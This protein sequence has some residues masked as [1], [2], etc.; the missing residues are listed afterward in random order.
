M[1]LTLVL[2]RMAHAWHIGLRSRTYGSP[3]CRNRLYI[4]GVR[5]DIADKASFN[6]AIQYFR[7]GLP[8]VS[9]R[10]CSVLDVTTYMSGLCE[11]GEVQQIPCKPQ[12]DSCV[13]CW[14][15][16]VARD[17]EAENI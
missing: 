13:R 5:E 6:A 4:I 3:Q 1:P 14:V 15:A 11:A 17:L 2:P 10:A 7:F 9:E 12:Q 16:C 8:V